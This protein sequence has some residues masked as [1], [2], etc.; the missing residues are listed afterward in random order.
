MTLIHHY[1]YFRVYK[2]PDLWVGFVVHHDGPVL[3]STGSAT[4]APDV[5][6]ACLPIATCLLGTTSKVFTP[7]T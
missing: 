5:L 1:W 3:K 6:L 2:G 4:A 7:D